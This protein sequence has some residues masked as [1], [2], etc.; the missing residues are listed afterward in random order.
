M[1]AIILAGRLQL[2]DIPKRLF[3]GGGDEII[4]DCAVTAWRLH[5]EIN[6]LSK[7]AEDGH[8]ERS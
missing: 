3:L 5:T 4:K 6:I 8:L 1:A 2:E 7:E